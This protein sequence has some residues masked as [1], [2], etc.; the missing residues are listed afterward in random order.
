[1]AGVAGGAAQVL[2]YHH[3]V[4][5]EIDLASLGV[6][7]AFWGHIHSDDGR[8]TFGPFDIATNNV[9]DGERSYRLVRVTTGV[10][11]PAVTLPARAAGTSLDVQYSP[12]NDGTRSTVTAHITNNLSQRLDHAQLGFVMPKG[13]RRSR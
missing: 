8:L 4:T 6:E 5:D 12:A 9:C 7:A 1:L 2:F 11:R 3:D 13:L 10:I